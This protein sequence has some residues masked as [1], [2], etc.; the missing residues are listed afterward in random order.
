[1][2]DKGFFFCDG[3]ESYLRNLIGIYKV[4]KIGD[5]LWVEVKVGIK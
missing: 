2:I 4:G 1:M 5:Y 3:L